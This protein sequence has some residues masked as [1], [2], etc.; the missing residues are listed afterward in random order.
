M[1]LR[2]I[3]AVAPGVRHAGGR[4]RNLQPAPARCWCG[5]AECY[6]HS[7]YCARC[8][9]RRARAKLAN[10]RLN[11]AQTVLQCVDAC[12]GREPIA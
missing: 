12:N 3:G 1:T 9:Y 11:A 4:A 7:D 2:A 6:E 8:G 10:V 5:A